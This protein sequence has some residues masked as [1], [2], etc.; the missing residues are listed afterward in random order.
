MHIT[1]SFLG[2]IRFLLNRARER[3]WVRPA[4]MCVVSILAA[5][6]AGM[7]DRFEFAQAAP[8]ISSDSIETLLK[9]IS[10]SMLV[11]AVFAVGAMLSAY[12]SASS[13]ATPRAFSL[14]LADDVSQNALSSFVGAF[15]FSI[16]ALVA[17]MNGYY[18]KAGR[19]A[20][21]LLTMTVFIIVILSFVRWVDNIARLGRLGT[22]IDKVEK[23]AEQ[24]LR[25]RQ[26]RPTMGAAKLGGSSYEHPVHSEAIDYV[27]R[28]EVAELQ[29]RAEEMEIRIQVAALPG[30][31]TAPDKPLAY[32]DTEVDQS[33]L[34]QIV[35][36]F[37]IGGD[38]TFD[39]DPRFG[40]IV[41]AEIASRALSPG[42][43]DPGTAIDI[44][45]TL[46]RLFTI[47]A[48][49]ETDCKEDG[50]EVEFDRVEVPELSVSDMF[51]DAFNAIARDGASIFEVHV[52]L[53]KGFK[54]LAS[55][56]NDEMKEAAKAHARF[57]L[58][59][60]EKALRLP[61]EIEALHEV[62]LK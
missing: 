55:L 30:T 7:A 47:W 6:L 60:A 35:D 36:A 49:G 57:A 1:E 8:D 62:A 21:F 43:N 9:I 45:G 31:L 52:R 10:S 59:H 61:D 4:A 56:G 54:A 40:L 39:E 26:A 17:L 58:Q 37:V 38:R 2:R 11:I 19:F 12:R 33:G 16:I 48:N 25:R 34:E 41:L 3:L 50:P 53:Q 46:V 51:D 28:V 42:V 22:T 18:E 5:L 15:I 24:A 13:G 14:V 20:L 27:Q 29:A 32:V 44:I 23:A